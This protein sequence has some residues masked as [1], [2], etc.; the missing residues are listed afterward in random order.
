M[1]FLFDIISLLEKLS[2]QQ[3]LPLDGVMQA[4]GASKEDTAQGFEYWGCRLAIGTKSRQNN[5][6]KGTGCTFDLLLGRLTYEI[7]A[8][9]CPNYTDEQRWGKP[10]NSA[11][12]YVVSPK[13]FKLSWNNSELITGDVLAEKKSLKNQTVLTY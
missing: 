13:P 7:F 10:F 9:Y 1:V 2:L 5:R 3:W 4:P 11:K 12:K 6:H 8:A